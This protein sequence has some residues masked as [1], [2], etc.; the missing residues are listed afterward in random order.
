MPSTPSLK[1]RFGDIDIYLF[2]QLL[3]ERFAP[4]MTVLDAGCGGG[5]NVVY[6]LGAGYEV[7]AVDKSPDAVAQV[8]S[9]A[10]RLAPRLPET[11]FRVETVEALSFADESF[12]VVLSSAVLHFAR[13]EE[14]WWRMVRDMWRVLAPGG[15]LWARTASTTG[16][17]AKVEHIDGRWYH[18]PD[19]SDRFLVDETMLMDATAALGG[20]LADPIKTVVVQGMRSMTT[21]CLRKA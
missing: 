12:D 4:P 9:L 14:H 8:R 7:S 5:R 13:D 20:E 6:L 18:L 21:W 3:R 11:N 2:D 17:E 1:Q 16:I 19:G 15:F 10:T